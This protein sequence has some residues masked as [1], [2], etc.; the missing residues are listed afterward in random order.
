MVRC[1]VMLYFN[2]R[3]GERNEARIQRFKEAMN[4]PQ[5]KDPNNLNLMSPG[6][7]GFFPLFLLLYCNVTNVR[8]RSVNIAKGQ[9]AKR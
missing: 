9:S 1:F 3:E 8:E 5:T 6:F 7:L 2:G 4:H